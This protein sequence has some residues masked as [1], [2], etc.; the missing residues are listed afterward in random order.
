M[1]FKKPGCAVIAIIYCVLFTFAHADE[2]QVN[3]DF[4]YF[5]NGD[6]PENWIWVLSDPDNWWLP[7]DGNQGKSKGKKIE[8]APTEYQGNMGAV[9]L[10]WSRKDKWG[11]AAITGR[12]V[13]LSKFRD[14]AELL[15]VIRVDHKPNKDVKLTINCG[16]DCSANM[17]IDDLLKE[18]PTNEWIALPIALNCFSKNGADLSKISTPFSI[19]TQGRLGLSIAKIFIQPM[20]KGDEGCGA[21]A[22]EAGEK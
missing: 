18:S 20:A 19:G 1:I 17:H 3:P 16:D 7:L 6:T 13:D 12:T 14:L 21:K 5:E 8:I 4:I 22:S 11:S 2:T 9:K 10:T 15:I